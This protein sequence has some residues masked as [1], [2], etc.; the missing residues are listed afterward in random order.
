MTADTAVD[1]SSNQGRGLVRLSE[2]TSTVANTDE[3]VRNRAVRD[4][5][6]EDLG[7]I[8]DLIIDEADQ[9]VRFLQ[10]KQGGFLGIGQ[11]TILLP[12]DTI[13]RID[14]HEIHVNQDRTRIA[15]SPAYDPEL[16]D[17]RYYENLYG[18]YGLGPFW[19]AGYTYPPYPHY[20]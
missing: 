20:P 11:Q 7:T 19:G 3:D 10:I 2:S 4:V 14:D 6:G 8:R 13:V 18:Y 16:T 17:D 9:K 15:G 12:V 1:D 5:H